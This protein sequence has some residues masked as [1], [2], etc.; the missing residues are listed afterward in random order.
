MTNKLR[1]WLAS[2]QAIA[3]GAIRA[4]GGRWRYCV[5]CNKRVPAFLPWRGGWSAAPALMRELQV[6]GSDLDQFSCPCCGA[7]DRDRHL[8]LYLEHS[9]IAEAM[10]GARILHFAPE[11]PLV[12]WI[13]S[14]GPSL[15]VLADLYPSK[16]EIRRIDLEAVPFEDGSFDFVIANHVLEHV[17]HLNR[18]TQEIARIL[19]PGARAILQTP[20]CMGL[21]STLEDAAVQSESARLHLYGQEDHVRLFGKDVY[22]RIAAGGLTAAPIPHD[23]YLV[24]FDPDMY[25]VNPREDLMLFLGNGIPA[26]GH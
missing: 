22:K 11:P 6:V 25:G 10:R 24:G 3:A 14:L 5:I 20:W 26:S 4:L 19:A 17:A 8:R 21:D 16:P 13:G 18:A 9:G 12:S 7:N 15:H 1:G 23:R 2:T